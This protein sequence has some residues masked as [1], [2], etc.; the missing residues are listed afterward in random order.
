MVFGYKRYLYDHKDKD[1]VDDEELQLKTIKGNPG[2]LP[3]SKT[4]L[5]YVLRLTVILSASALLLWLCFLLARRIITWRI[6][7]RGDYYHSRK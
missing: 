1:D 2:R 7:G 5:F 3:R 6:A 4:T